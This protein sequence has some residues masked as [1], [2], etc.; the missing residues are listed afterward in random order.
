MG[1]QHR[2]DGSVALV[3]LGAL[4]L[5]YGSAVAAQAPAAQSPMLML[6]DAELARRIGF[7]EQRLDTA[8]PAALTWQWG[9]TAAYTASFV[10]NLDYA[11]RVDDNDR[12]VRAVVAAAKSAVAAVQTARLWHDPLAATQGARPMREVPGEG[13]AAEEQRLAVGESLLLTSAEQAETR[14]S[15]QRHLIEIGGNLLGGAAILALG[16]GGDALWSTLIGIGVGETQ[17]WTQPWRATGDLRDYDGEFGGM[18][19]V[20]I[21]A[22]PGGGGLQLTL[23]F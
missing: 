2:H 19:T 3:A 12:R 11:I 23:R 10:F 1:S 15:L 6:S 14:Y 9:W 7:L 13:R 16:D 5:L 21:E 17:I 18:A 22:L 8:R 20:S 4:A